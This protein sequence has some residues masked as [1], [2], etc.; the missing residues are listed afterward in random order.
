MNTWTP[1]TIAELKAD[2]KFSADFLMNEAEAAFNNLNSMSEFVE[3]WE[4][5]LLNNCYF[6][7]HQKSWFIELENKKINV[8]NL[9]KTTFKVYESAK[10][11]LKSL[12][13][14]SPLFYGYE[15]LTA[16]Y[17]KRDAE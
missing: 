12:N 7:E 8:S 9:Y 16:H 3:N 11:F 15:K 5:F 14:Y 10:E 13:M 17:Y 6:D 4:N 1:N 2:A